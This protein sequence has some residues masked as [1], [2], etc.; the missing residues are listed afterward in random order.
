MD[1]T[2]YR[3]PPAD[4][5]AIVPLDDLVAVFHRASGITHLVTS[6]APE[7]LDA[8]ADRWR[9][10]D[11]LET[12]FELVGGDRSSLI[13]ALDELAAAGLVERR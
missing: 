10:L 4:G 7:L 1:A 3:A 5:L 9:T 13:A 6:P 11:D 12:E 2:R 8:L